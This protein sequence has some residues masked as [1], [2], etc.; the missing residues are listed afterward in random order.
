[1]LKYFILILIHNPDNNNGIDAPN[2]YSC[3]YEQYGE[4]KHGHREKTENQK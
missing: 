2:N 4:L 1:M 3:A